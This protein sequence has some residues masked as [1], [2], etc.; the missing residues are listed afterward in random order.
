VLLV[1]GCGGEA[2]GASGLPTAEIRLGGEALIVE[3]AAT[4]EARRQGLMNREEL[5]AD[6]GM[7][8]VFRGSDYRSFWMKDTSIALSVAYIREDGM[9]TGIYELE[10]FSLESVDSAA[11]VKYALEVN[12]GTFRRLGV[13]PGDRVLLPPGLP[14]AENG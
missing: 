10:P 1:S 9:I 2:A 14:E 7:L 11:P 4:P 6:R 13:G 12:R 8:F 5:P 3:V